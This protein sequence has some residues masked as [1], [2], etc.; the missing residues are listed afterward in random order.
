MATDSLGDKDSTQAWRHERA[1]AEMATDR[2]GD[3]D[4][5]QAW[6]HSPFS[7]ALSTHLLCTKAARGTVMSEP[8]PHH[9]L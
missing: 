6:R 1:T 9:G 7:Q 8:P 3:K 4:G 5:T 2:L